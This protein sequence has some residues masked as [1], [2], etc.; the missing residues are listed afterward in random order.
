MVRTLI[1]LED[2]LQHTSISNGLRFSAADSRF[3]Y[4]CV[5]FTAR[6]NYFNFIYLILAYVFVRNSLKLLRGGVC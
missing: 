3:S 6:K 2:Y 5:R 4:A 1:H